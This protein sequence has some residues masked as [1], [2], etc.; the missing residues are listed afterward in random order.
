MPVLTSRFSSRRR[1]QAETDTTDALYRH[2]R[3]AVRTYARGAIPTQDAQQRRRNRKMSSLS[4]RMAQLQVYRS[5]CVYSVG[6]E[7]F[8]FLLE[9]LLGDDTSLSSC[10]RRHSK[11]A[12]GPIN[13]ATSFGSFEPGPG[14]CFGF[15]SRGR[16][17]RVLPGPGLA[18][19]VAILATRA[20]SCHV[21]SMGP[22]FPTK[23]P[24]FGFKYGT[25]IEMRS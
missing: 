16:L 12:R 3:R 5:K 17:P 14:C 15:C 4:Q 9:G 23:W 24:S 10:V 19:L 7:G 1:R 18:V 11:A 22:A 6:N 25:V 20:A 2:N 8:N 21:S 13:A